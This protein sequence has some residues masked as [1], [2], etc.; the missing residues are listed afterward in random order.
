[1]RISVNNLI[2]NETRRVFDSASSGEDTSGWDFLTDP[3][4]THKVPAR[5][6]PYQQVDDDISD[7]PSA[8]I[9]QGT[10][11][12][13]GAFQS[14]DFLHIR[15]APPMGKRPP[16]RGDDGLHRVN[17][18]RAAGKMH[19]EVLGRDKQSIKLGILYEGTCYDLWH[20]GVAIILGMDISL[21]TKGRR[22]SWPEDETA[23]WAVTA[24]DAFAG[25]HSE[26]Q[27]SQ[28]TPASRQSSIG[29]AY[30]AVYLPLLAHNA[31]HNPMITPARNSAS[32]LRAPLP[33]QQTPDYSFE[34]SP[35]PTPGPSEA[36]SSTLGQDTRMSRNDVSPAR[37]ITMKINLTKFSRQARQE[38]PFRISGIILVD[39]EEED[40]LSLPVFR[41]FGCV[42]NELSTFVS[43]Q[44]VDTS[45]RI[46]EESSN[47]RRMVRVGE[48]IQC[49]KETGLFIDAIGSP[50]SV[51]A[52]TTSGDEGSPIA[53]RT[54][55]RKRAT[56]RARARA[57]LLDVS[58]ASGPLRTEFP[59]EFPSVLAIVTPLTESGNINKHCVRVVIP[60]Y[61]LDA[62]T[63]QFALAMA[64]D[65]ITGKKKF[66]PT[67]DV[68]YAS[69][70]GHQVPVDVLPQPA[71]SPTLS[72]ADIG[73]ESEVI[74]ERQYVVV[75][76][77]EEIEADSGPVEIMYLVGEKE[78]V[79][80]S[81]GSGKK[82]K[83]KAEMDM[84]VLLPCFQLPVAMYEVQV[85]YPMSKNFIHRLIYYVL[86]VLSRFN[87]LC[88]IFNTTPSIYD[89]FT[90][91]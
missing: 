15:W 19:C 43:L 65:P 44:T 54:S 31:E 59:Q 61:S 21:D 4:V 66:Q 56:A 77:L 53:H 86:T 75:A 51:A 81:T 71:S 41:I 67:I 37:A 5:K 42:D 16:N 49:D 38:F 28:T 23:G 91:R 89:F 13:Q 24:G 55:P 29:S 46:G 78:T 20:P 39:I 10:E 22:V 18:P 3:P 63:I 88:E 64:R 47:T 35:T 11:V 68:L 12:I 79:P 32:L 6:G 25:L 57:E 73:S 2:N 26:A 50:S 60:M 33:N 14:T 85:E 34:A 72:A 80:E 82:G 62:D 58:D 17:V 8:Q 84:D 52:P 9:T 87:P 1:M 48:E 27:Y 76:H 90:N 69:Y 74:G 30:G 45:I 83:G 36:P 70:A 7:T 40:F